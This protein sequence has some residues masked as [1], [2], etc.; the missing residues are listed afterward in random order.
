[1]GDTDK[2]AWIIAFVGALFGGL[3]AGKVGAM[4]GAYVPVIIYQLG[5]PDFSEEAGLGSSQGGKGVSRLLVALLASAVP[6]FAAWLA[7]LVVFSM[8]S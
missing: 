6:G 1:M 5:L 7:S 2:K 8:T 3:I 4:A